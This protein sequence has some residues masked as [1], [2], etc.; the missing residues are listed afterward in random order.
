V[1]CWVFSCGDITYN[2]RGTNVWVRNLDMHVLRKGT[3]L[4]VSLNTCVNVVW[5]LFLIVKLN[6][7]VVWMTFIKFL[8]VPE[9]F[10]TTN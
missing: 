5:L 6:L 2:I 7:N 10:S 8:Y 4:K 9:L 3:E 1:Q